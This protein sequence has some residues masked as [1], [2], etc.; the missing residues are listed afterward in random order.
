MRKPFLLSRRTFLTATLATA[1]A[2]TVR[3]PAHADLDRKDD[4]VDAAT[5]KILDQA[6]DQGFAQVRAPGVVAAVTQGGK[7]WTASRGATTMGGAELPSLDVHTRVGSVT[8]TMVGT[9]T[10]Q[11]LDEGLLGADDTIDRWFPDFP[12]ANEINIRMLGTMASGIGS[13]TL[14]DAWVDR[15]FADPLKA[16]EPTELIRAAAAVKRP[17]EPD[18]GFQYCN[19][20]FVMLGMIVEKLRGKPLGQVLQ[21]H[22][23]GPLGM[24]CSSYPSGNDLPE[25]YWS[26]YTLQSVEGDTPIEATHWSPTF[27]AGA[28]QAVSNLHDLRIWARALGT[29]ALLKPQT[30]AFRLQP[31]PYSTKGGRSYCFAL[32][33]NN[34]WL[35]HSGELPGYNTQVAYL[36]KKDLAIAVMANS[37]L[38]SS[39]GLHPA[40]GVYHALAA[41]LVPEYPLE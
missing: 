19:T 31:N 8:K 14:D 23:W 4:V 3:G 30:Q 25:P 10:L 38:D 37:D 35:E 26:G 22:L 27:G 11:A 16:W 33:S 41:A 12:R 34:G 32:G 2:A 28:G 9:L 15:Y 39:Q 1:V 7:V 21:E 40:V 36:P 29:G 17:F 13:Y 20:N 5:G 6:L 24:T 18:Q